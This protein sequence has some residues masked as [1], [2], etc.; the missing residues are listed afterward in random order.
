MHKQQIFAFKTDMGDQ[1]RVDSLKDLWGM[2]EWT[3]VDSWALCIKRRG[4]KPNP[5]PPYIHRE[6]DTKSSQSAIA[7]A[8]L[9]QQASLSAQDSET[10]IS[11]HHFFLRNAWGSFWKMLLLLY[12]DSLTNTKSCKEAGT[13]SWADT[14]TTENRSTWCQPFSI[15]TVKGEKQLLS[16]CVAAP[17]PFP[18]HKE[19]KRWHLQ[20]HISALGLVVHSCREAYKAMAVLLSLLPL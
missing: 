19:E 14:T 18:K 20:C 16:S 12:G 15:S 9:Q 6:S 5:Y 8:E 11:M 13:V 17:T 1:F 10:S 4:R 7:Q 3:L 2:P